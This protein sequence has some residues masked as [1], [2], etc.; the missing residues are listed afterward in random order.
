[1][2]KG[3]SASPTPVRNLSSDI[4]TVVVWVLSSQ[5]DGFVFACR[6]F[7]FVSGAKSF[8]VCVGAWTFFFPAL[9]VKLESNVTRMPLFPEA[10]MF[11]ET[12]AITRPE[13]S[14]RS[15]PTTIRAGARHPAPE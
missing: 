15:S 14:P 7:A 5:G 13:K 11:K 8:R 9:F 6:H 4:H 1:M 3:W 2:G 12:V 10:S